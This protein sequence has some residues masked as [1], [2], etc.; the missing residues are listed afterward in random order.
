MSSFSHAVIIGNLTRDAELKY[1]NS[2]TAMCKFSVAVNV[3][4]KVGDEWKDVGNFYNVVVWG[5]DAEL[6]N[7]YLTK[8]KSVAV[9]G[10]LSQRKWAKDGV[11]HISVEVNADTVKLLGGKSGDGSKPEGRKPEPRKAEPG[12]DFPDD[13]PF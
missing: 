13:I 8:G 5:K 1:T 7:Q 3:R 9:S 11:D 6:L 4:E 12:D 2:G 10:E